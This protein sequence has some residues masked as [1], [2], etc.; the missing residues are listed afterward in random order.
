M[1]DCL[2]NIESFLV[3]SN[4]KEKKEKKKIIIQVTRNGFRQKM[5]IY[6]L[7]LGNIVHLAIGDYVPGD[8]LFLYGFSLLVDE[9]SLTGESEFVAII[10]K[11]PFLLFG[12]KVQ[13]GS[14]KMLV[15]TVGMRTQWGKLR[16]TL[17][18]GGDDETPLQV[19]LNGVATFIEKIGL[20]LGGDFI[21]E[22]KVVKLIKVEPFNS[23]KQRMRVVIQFPQGGYRAHIIGASKIVLASCKKV[24]DVVVNVDFLYDVT[25]NHL[26]DTIESFA[27]EALNT[28]CLAYM[29]VE[30]D[31]S[32]N[33]QIPSDGYTC[34]RIVGIKDPFRPGVKESV[35]VC[36]SAGMSYYWIAIE[37]GIGIAIEGLE[38]GEKSLKQMTELIPRIQHIF[39][40]IGYGCTSC[41]S[42]KGGITFTKTLE[43]FTHPNTLVDRYKR[44]RIFD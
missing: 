43:T 3:S 12:T 5:L 11:N 35:A 32:A 44:H 39:H 15:T 13:D 21:P 26:K 27:K 17:R 38:F 24:L 40:I 9:S 25:T 14:C 29:E 28:L 2:R 6:G 36:R 37:C 20:S 8:G 30:V 33:Q 19:K 34:I 1:N 4:G 10:A 7:L 18:E 31:F 23:A 16:A 42:S 22:Y 41:I